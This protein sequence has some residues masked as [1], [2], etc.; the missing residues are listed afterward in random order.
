MGATY[1]R[2]MDQIQAGDPD[3]AYPATA[4]QETLTE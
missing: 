4:F 1:P 2:N 3:H